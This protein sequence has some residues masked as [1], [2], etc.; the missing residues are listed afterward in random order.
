MLTF[1]ELNIALFER[2]SSPINLLIL[3]T[4]LSSIIPAANYL[5]PA[6]LYFIGAIV[7]LRIKKQNLITEILPHLYILSC[8]SYLGASFLE[9]IAIIPAIFA[10]NNLKPKTQSSTYKNFIINIFIFILGSYSTIIFPELAPFLI[11]VLVVSELI[12]REKTLEDLQYS[13]LR[14]LVLLGLFI[15]ALTRIQLIDLP[16]FPKGARL[17]PISPLNKYGNPIFGEYYTLNFT[18]YLA[19]K[20]YLLQWIPQLGLFFIALL[21]CSN[22]GKRSV[23]IFAAI[24]ISICFVPPDIG[25]NWVLFPFGFILRVVP[26][27][28]LA[29][30]MIF[31]SIIII[32][33]LV[34]TD[35]FSLNKNIKFSLPLFGLL[36]LALIFNDRLKLKNES[37][38]SLKESISN[39][40]KQSCPEK[41]KTENIVNTN[42]TIINN[43]IKEITSSIN[44]SSISNITD[45]NLSTRWSTNG[46]Q[47]GDEKI[48]ISFNKPISVNL[49]HL[50][51]GNFYTDYPRD[52]K[53]IING[54]VQ[55]YQEKENCID[56]IGWT[57]EGVPYFIKPRDLIMHL[58]SSSRTEQIILE[59]RGSDKTFDWSIAELKIYGNNSNQ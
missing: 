5:L 26:G 4:N 57:K 47:N 9:F 18:N 23:L 11:V 36:F 12:K 21:I 24:T 6:I 15:F 44:N 48:V 35:T 29:P 37:S 2:E 54:K 27:S 20:N 22:I 1:P 40:V 46:R 59:Q 10:L 31:Q 13:N 52:L 45:L 19:L 30:I 14:H 16:Y 58:E 25:R 41:L 38:N 7:N 51:L 42:D 56:G 3:S 39:Y 8:A 17:T 33:C 49:I 32:I 50:D 43:E 55:N 28:N 53:I 34:F